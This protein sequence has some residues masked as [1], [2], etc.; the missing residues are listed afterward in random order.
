MCLL[1]L[2]SLLA[3]QPAAPTLAED[4]DEVLAGFEDNE[5]DAPLEDILEGF[6]DDDELDEILEGF[7]DE[8]LEGSNADEASEPSFWRISGAF[9]LGASYNL[10]EHRPPPGSAQYGGL[11]RLRTELDLQLDL[12]LPA[13]WKARVAGRAFYDFAYRIHGRSN[14]TDDVLDL[15]QWEA[16][17]T[18]VYLQG[19]LHRDLDLKLGRQIVNW[20]T[21]E[22]FRVVDVLNPL[23]NREPG[24]VD[25]EDLRLPVVMTKLDYYFGDWDLSL[26]AVHERRFND[27]PV[28]GSD[29]FPPLLGRGLSD[30]EPAQTLE[31]SEW[32]VAL[33]GVFEGWDLGFFAARHYEDTPRVE[34]PGFELVDGVPILLPTRHSRL[35]MLGSTLNV[36]LGNWL[37]RGEVA[38]HDG[39]QYFH[40]RERKTSRLDV[41][42]GIDYAGFS[43]TLIAVDVV[44]RRV[45]GWESALLGAP[46]F[47]RRN[48][49]EI[50][51]RIQRDFFRE[52]LHVMLLAVGFGKKLE[53]GSAVRLGADYD[54]LDALTIGGGILLFQS[55]DLP[56]LSAF[57]RNDRVYVQAKYSF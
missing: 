31:N 53:D 26:I 14:Y 29:F 39:L 40:L 44:N 30:E 54:L 28:F 45:H 4:L 7:E 50:A 15:Y 42:V 36:A 24:L 37:L 47:T 32:A 11:S 56:P 17:F 38:Y 57:G 12:D 27:D 34:F 10:R 5:D 18:E 23:D 13:S 22:T 55:G 35:L 19:S 20:G 8:A 46:D 43:E 49:V 25:I 9:S 2:A 6:D 21:G 52:K 16:E 3:G 33:R 41:L 1:L 48:S 51:F